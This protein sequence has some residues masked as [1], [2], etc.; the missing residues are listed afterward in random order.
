[1][2]GFV[3]GFVFAYVVVLLALLVRDANK[4][5]VTGLLDYP[6]WPVILWRKWARRNPPK[7]AAPAGQ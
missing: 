7:R 1:M 6:R 2:M 5:K 3:A 4:Q